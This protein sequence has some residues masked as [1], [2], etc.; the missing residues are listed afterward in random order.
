MK[1]SHVL[2]ASLVCALVI[3]YALFRALTP[4]PAPLVA[5]AD[6]P[7][8][9]A[10]DPQP[11]QPSPRYSATPAPAPASVLPSVPEVPKTPQETDRFWDNIE[12]LAMEA[13]QE[14]S[15]DPLTE[16]QKTRLKET[17]RLKKGRLS[18][19]LP[20]PAEAVEELVFQV[21][22]S[23]PGAG[24]GSESASLGPP[25]AGVAGVS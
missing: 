24:R 7:P 2:V 11:P 23:A 12:T 8:P 19:P 20:D 15:P 14:T 5:P 22:E 17:V 4:Y 13:L 3:Q 6:C 9:A 1:T 10:R 21:E 16:E 25:P 18:D